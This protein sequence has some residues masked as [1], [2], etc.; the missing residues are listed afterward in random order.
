MT[1]AQL[2]G[3]QAPRTLL[4]RDQIRGDLYGPDMVALPAGDFLMGDNHK[5]GDDNEHPVHRVTIQSA[6][7]PVPL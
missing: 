5:L 3:E 1:A 6:L 2:T 7:C 4:F